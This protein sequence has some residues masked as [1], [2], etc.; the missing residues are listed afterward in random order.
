MNEF[1]LI[2]LI[3]AECA[4]QRAD[5]RI[6]NGDDAAA[7]AIPDGHE[8]LV[9]TDTLVAGRHFPMDT[10][11]E[12][13]GWKSLAVNLSDLAAMGATPAFALLALCLPSADSDWVRAFAR[14]FADLARLHDVA[15]IGGDT[16]RGPLTITVTA[17]GFAPHGRA[18]KRSGARPGDTIVVCGDIGLAAAGLHHLTTMPERSRD[19]LDDSK[20]SM[21]RWLDAL[22]RPTPQI[23]QGL[24]LRHYATSAIDIS[25]GLAADLGHVL[26]QSGVGADIQLPSIP[27]FEALSQSF[28]ADLAIRWVLCGGDDYVLLA[29]LSPD[30]F[31][32][33][34]AAFQRSGV[35][36]TPIGNVTAAP[37]LRVHDIRGSAL[38]L[39][40]AGWDHF[41]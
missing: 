34:R 36:L 7:V 27:G 10:R 11:P 3:K 13:I 8:L 24:L 14:G 1:A 16:S 37:G 5:V 39:D 19:G 31:D 18:L 12:D 40:K 23:E 38:A 22:N 4:L 41:A 29:T 15:L 35:M 21:Q 33:A 2:D 32:E 26:R 6:G 20:S 28:G 9:C 25:D 17:L 30:R